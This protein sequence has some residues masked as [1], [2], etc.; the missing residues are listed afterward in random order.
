MEVDYGLVAQAITVVLAIAGLY[1]GKKY[2]KFKK[3]VR[4]FADAIED[5][6]VTKE[7]LKE[8]FYDIFGE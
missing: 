5:D 3:F 1:F 7:E 8:M 2:R 4:D 6:S